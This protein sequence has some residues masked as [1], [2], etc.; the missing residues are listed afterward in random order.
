M[1]KRLTM[2]RLPIW[3][4][5]CCAPLLAQQPISKVAFTESNHAIGGFSPYGEISLPGLRVQIDLRYPR[6]KSE[7]GNL[8]VVYDPQTGHYFW[9]YSKVQSPKDIS[10]L[11]ALQ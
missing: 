5:F 9:R 11:D 6:G 1:I 8:A 7:R 4:L 3:S 2:Q 10:F